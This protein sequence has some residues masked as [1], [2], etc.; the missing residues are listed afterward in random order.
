[1]VLGALLSDRVLSVGA[2]RRVVAPPMQVSL[3]GEFSHI[4]P[5]TPVKGAMAG[6]VF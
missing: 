2:T 1:M 3:Q 4:G 5:K 6:P